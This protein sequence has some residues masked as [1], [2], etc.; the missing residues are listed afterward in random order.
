MARQSLVPIYS[1]GAEPDI[2]PDPVFGSR[3]TDF[4][5][6][7]GHPRF[8]PAKRGGRTSVQLG[9]D[10]YQFSVPVASVGG[11][12]ISAGIAMSFNSRVWNNDNGTMTF[13]Y[14]SAFP[15]PGW[16]M[17]S[18]KIIRNYNPTATGEN[19]GI[20]TANSPGD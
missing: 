20:G 16:S 18:D 3:A 8:S 4:R 1:D 17:G 14:V 12:G 2:D 5:N 6:A 10:N 7:V 9:S 13:N 15:A 19:T 11:R